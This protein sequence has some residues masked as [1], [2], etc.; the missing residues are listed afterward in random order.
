[1][2]VFCR[3]HERGFFAPRQNP[4]K[5]DN[6]GHILGEI[7]FAGDQRSPAELHWQ[8]CCNCEHFCPISANG[9]SLELCPVC[10]RR[11]AQMYVCDRCL[12]VSFE[13]STPVE[14][15]NFTLTS[16]GVPRPACPGC[17]QT[18]SGEVREHVCDDLGASFTTALAA[19]PI[20]RERLD[21]GPSFPN[22]VS[23]FLRKTKATNKSN[24][25]FDYDT[26]LFVEVEDGEFVAVPDASELNRVM[27]VPRVAQFSDSREFYEIYQD[28]YHHRAEI[29]A[30]EVFI[31]EPAWAERAEG[32]WV[33]KSEGMLEVVNDHPQRKTRKIRFSEPI[34]HHETAEA[35]IPSRR[36]A[37]S[38]IPAERTGQ[39]A[40]QGMRPAE[41]AIPAERRAIPAESTGPS[42]IQGMRPAEPVIPAER[43]AIPAGRTVGPASPSVER[44]NA[45]WESPEYKDRKTLR[46][47]ASA[48]EPP[49]PP[50]QAAEPAHPAE[51]AAESPMS[52]AGH[53]E[54]AIPPGEIETEAPPS[55]AAPSR[56][57]AAGGVCQHCGSAI[58]EKY[59]FCWNC[60]KPMQAAKQSET[61]RPKNPSRRL[62]IDMDDTP[63]L[64]PLEEHRRPIFS[65]LPHEQ[66]GLKRGNGSGLKLMLVL[67]VAVTALVSGMAGTW[68]LKRAPAVTPAVLAAETAKAT[69]QSAQEYVPSVNVS[70]TPVETP[71]PAS[72]PAASADEELRDLKQRR[73][74]GTAADRRNVMRDIVRLEHEYPNDY[75]FPYERA[76]LSAVAPEEKSRDAA[77]QALFIAAQRAIKAGKSAEM[78]HGLEADRFRDFRKLARGHVEW[79]QLVQSLKNR[80]ATRLA[81]NAHSTMALE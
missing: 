80:D 23:Q 62:I 28:Y 78:L 3:E 60:G 15:K 42:A 56:S 13:A 46:S 30:G 66:K 43:R 65:E 63:N 55:L 36:T 7:N 64:P 17:L 19:C 54:A 81:T 14:T 21:I 57:A 31:H 77:F 29:R 61:K 11:T 74:K 41:P 1:M 58:E 24:V 33:F 47:A 8:Y 39:S 32:G 72:L 49:I 12:T 73:T 16:E 38:V 5:C 68:W 22:L 50:A 6:R 34:P 71:L 2:R 44:G 67:A 70:T 10:T 37:E 52:A 35:A 25:T 18:S 20:C 40:I 51:R 27:I 76:K 26:G 45:W 59:A 75:R 4:I 69:S 79:S 53:A 48:G 9:E